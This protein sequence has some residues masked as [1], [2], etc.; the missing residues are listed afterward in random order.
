[1][2]ALGTSST[3]ITIV[4]WLVVGKYDYQMVNDMMSSLTVFLFLH[5]ARFNLPLE[6]RK[7]LK[8]QLYI[9]IFLYCTLDE[10]YYDK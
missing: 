1:M 10:S 7:Y 6:E 2:V 9:V 3:I 4:A 8:I 5:N